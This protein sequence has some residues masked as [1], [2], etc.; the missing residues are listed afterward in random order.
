MPITNF[1]INTLHKQVFGFGRGEPYDGAQAEK[2]TAADAGE[3][4]DPPQ[5]ND[6]EGT[7]FVEM[8]D[9]LK[10][11]T[12]L[13]QPIFMPM[14]IGGLMLP[15]EPTVVIQMEKRI[16]RTPLTGSES[17]GDVLELIAVSNY[18]ITIRGIALN[19]ASTKVYPE[20]LVK[21]I[22]ELALRKESLIVEN[23]LTALLGIERLAILKL[24]LPEMTGVQH[25]QAYQLDCISDN[26]FDL[27][28]E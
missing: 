20:D 6:E 24:T 17:V 12:P 18:M 15:N 11:V 28:I 16:V 4:P 22:H 9:T 1:D 8:R 2:P 19:Y 3:Y 26:P 27:E 21:E 25:A 7:E 13:G 23:A 14:R 10:A 5:V